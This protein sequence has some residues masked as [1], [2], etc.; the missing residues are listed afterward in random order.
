MIKL[1][2]K[3]NRERREI[4]KN[5]EPKYLF[6]RRERRS[7]TLL[8]TQIQKQRKRKRLMRRNLEGKGRTLRKVEV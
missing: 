8:D 4:N 2:Q 7:G 3:E 5:M 6:C 1:Q